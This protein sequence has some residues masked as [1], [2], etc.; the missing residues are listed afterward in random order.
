MHLKR[1]SR[2]IQSPVYIRT[3]QRCIF[4]SSYSEADLAKVSVPS[5]LKQNVAVSYQMGLCHQYSINEIAL[6]KM[7]ARK[8][9]GEEV[10]KS[11]PQLSFSTVQRYIS[12][13]Q[14]TLSELPQKSRGR[15]HFT[16]PSPHSKVSYQFHTITMGSP[17]QII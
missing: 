6:F 13:K 14:P 15:I 11:K 8:G 12:Q 3:C 7:P 5:F 1:N 2:G 9:I 10:I 4:S 17:T 16:H